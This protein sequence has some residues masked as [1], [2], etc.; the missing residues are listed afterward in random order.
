VAL[1]DAHGPEAWYFAD[2]TEGF[3]TLFLAEEPTWEA[4]LDALAHNRVAAVRRDDQSGG[5]TWIQAP[6][7]EVRDAVLAQADRWR[8]WDNPAIARPMVSMVAIGPG[9][10]F[11]RPVPERGVMLRVRVGWISTNH[12]VPIRPLATLESL[13][14]DGRPV[15]PVASRVPG[16]LAANAPRADWIAALADLAPGPHTAEARVKVLRT[17]AEVSQTIRFDVTGGE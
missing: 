6:S 5:A 14:V 12:G 15:T 7:A 4:W 11:E 2:R 17:G 10:P 16:I 13:T 9:E 3:R 8:W 1:Q